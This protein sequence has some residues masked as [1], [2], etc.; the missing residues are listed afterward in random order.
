MKVHRLVFSPIEVNT[1]LISDG[2]GSCAVIDCG[3]YNNR[4]FDEFVGFLKKKDLKPV[5]LLNT[6]CHLD[7]IFGNRLFKEKFGFGALSHIKEESNRKMSPIHASVFGL[8]MEEAPE[9][10]A[11]IDEGN[12]LSFGP[13]QVKIIHIPGHA[14]G[15]LCFYFADEGL[16]FTGDALFAGSIGR[17]DLP[18]G[19]HQLLVKS[20]REKLFTLPADTVVWPG[21][22]DSTT[23]GTEIK[24]NPYFKV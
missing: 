24:T 20:I 18:G 2:K 14:P 3:C 6:H 8:E 19:D 17:S 15:G 21:H 10:D 9:P 11:Y 16:V 23:I 1:Y 13:W 4:E 12:D 7:H 5:L 22:G